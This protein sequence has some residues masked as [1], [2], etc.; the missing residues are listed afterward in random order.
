MAP[1]RVANPQPLVVDFDDEIFLLQRRGGISRYFTEVLN[2]F[3]EEPQLGVSPGLTFTRSDNE[4]LRNTSIGL[5]LKAQRHLPTLL[6]HIAGRRRYIH[7]YARS[8]KVGAS[9]NVAGR[10]L[11]ATYWSPRLR[12]LDA[13]PHLAASVMDLIPEQTGARQFGGPYGGR[14][15][16]LRRASV[17]F[18]ISDTTRDDLL[19]WYPWLDVPIITSPLAADHAVFNAAPQVSESCPP[20]PFALFVGKRGGYKN[21]DL[22]LSAI[23]M[24]R[25]TGTDLGIVVAGPA[26]S[27]SEMAAYNTTIPVNRT[28]FLEP[29]D[30]ELAALYRG[31]EVFVFPSSREGFGLPILEAMACG[32]PVVLSDIPVFREVASEAGV[33][34]VAEEPEGFAAAIE[35]IVL[36]DE[37]R[38][39]LIRRGLSR[40][41]EFSW[42]RTAALTALGYRQAFDV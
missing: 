39:T 28:T 24:V 13:H 19:E 36:S 35:Q 16:V 8:W 33:F 6:D 34:A 31:A 7:D 26:A 11:H 3:L 32:C 4:S 17:V 22:F 15:Y 41:K 25:S 10:M 23:E 14:E 5:H 12:D 29:S 38:T 40:A 27:V 20:Y 18:S 9:S 37:I 21:F 2:A 42:R 1:E 30:L